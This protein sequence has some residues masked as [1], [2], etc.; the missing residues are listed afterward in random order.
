M[1]PFTTGKTPRLFV[2]IAAYEKDRI[3]LLKMRPGYQWH[4]ADKRWSLPDTPENRAW[5]TQSESFIAE[6]IA[7]KLSANSNQI[8]QSPICHIREGR[9]YYKLP[10]E[11]ADWVAE[12]KKI[13]AYQWHKE[14]NYWSVPDTENNRIAIRQLHTRVQHSR[15]PSEKT[16]DVPTDRISIAVHPAKTSFLCVYV[17]KSCVETHLETVKK[18]H[19]RRW[20]KQLLSWEVPYT[21]LTLRFLRKYLSNAHWTFIPANNLPE[22]LAA[23]EK[24][25][26]YGKKKAHP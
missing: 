6:G 2:Q 23:D 19:G 17:P 16:P 25:I 4:P 5:L 3:A 26:E 13:T 12:I 11:C 14:E 9:I 22:R 20:N 24:A 21:L 18:I 15:Q 10:W 1:E 7:S 8:Q